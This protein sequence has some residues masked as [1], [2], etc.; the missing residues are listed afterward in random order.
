MPLGSPARWHHHG[1]DQQPA[2]AA[3][4]AR[5]QAGKVDP[6]IVVG[7]VSTP[8]AP[9]AT[10]H[11]LADGRAEQVPD[12]VCEGQAEGAPDDNPQHGTAD[13]AAA[14]AGAEGTC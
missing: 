5:L 12:P 10:Q 14:D 8:P 3:S 2:P 11:R 7:Q 4:G 9:V 1:L 6:D 13:V